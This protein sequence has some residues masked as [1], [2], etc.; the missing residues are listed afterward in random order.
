MFV[1]LGE[2]DRN[3]PVE[4]RAKIGESGDVDV[5]SFHQVLVQDGCAADWPLASRLVPLH[6]DPDGLLS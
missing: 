2:L 5:N 3:A 6:S 1:G 4:A